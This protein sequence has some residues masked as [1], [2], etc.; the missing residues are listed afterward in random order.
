MHRLRK[1]STATNGG[2]IKYFFKATGGH[3]PEV[4]AQLSPAYLIILFPTVLIHFSAR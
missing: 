4:K 3:K 1:L 2:I